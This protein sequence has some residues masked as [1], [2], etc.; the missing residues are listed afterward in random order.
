MNGFSQSLGTV[1]AAAI[2]GMAVV[3]HVAAPSASFTETAIVTG[4]GVG[5]ALLITPDRVDLGNKQRWVTPAAAA[6]AAYAVSGD[7]RHTAVAGAVFAIPA[8][9]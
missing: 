1:V 5:A 8:L 3:Y 9:L 4:A 7:L 2:G 6:G